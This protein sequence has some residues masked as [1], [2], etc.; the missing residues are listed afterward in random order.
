MALDHVRDFF[1]SFHGDPLGPDA[2][3][4]L[5]G[6]RWITHLCAPIFV[7]L[8]GIAA[9][10]VGKRRSK[11][12]LSAFLLSRG[13]WLI[14][15]EIT[16]V[17]LGWKFNFSNHPAFFLQVIW[18]IGI[19]M[20]FMSFLVFFS[21]RFSLII[22]ILVIA[23]HN[24]LGYMMPESSIPAIDPAWMGIERRIFVEVAGLRVLV[25]YPFLAWLGIMAL[26]YGLSPL[27]NLRPAKRA[28]IFAYL[29]FGSLLVFAL[30]RFT[31]FYGDTDVWVE[32]VSNL[33][34]FM[35]FMDV[36]KYPPSLLYTLATLGVGFLLLSVIE[37]VKLPFH[38][39]VITIGK[40][41]F[42][43]YILHIYLIHILAIIA[44]V[45]AGFEFSEMTGSFRDIPQDYGF[46]L[47]VV[48]LVWIGIVVALY[49]LCK[50][51]AG[52]KERTRSRILSYL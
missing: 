37:K 20:V 22:G 4:F 34:T 48:Y 18:A 2:G 11:S 3:P 46:G 32:G 35:R 49:P 16:I 44:G 45:M 33:D 21:T 43:Y 38:D 40:V 5:Y 8:A 19:S 30:L 47:W 23:G 7:L 9:G 39:Q 52:V 26:G 24:L 12:E 29:G 13:L 14:F 27:F 17:S 50:W 6:T 15:I 41:P 28:S 1:H 10:L 25:A 42:F 36:Q 31:N 51:F